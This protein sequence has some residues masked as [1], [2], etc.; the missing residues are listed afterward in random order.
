MCIGFRT[1]IVFT[2]LFCCIQHVVLCTY[3]QPYIRVYY[4]CM[5]VCV[6]VYARAFTTF[7]SV[8]AALGLITLHGNILLVFIC[9]ALYATSAT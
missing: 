2:T 6:H 3:V 7:C 5:R 9:Y 1:K 8:V 4:I